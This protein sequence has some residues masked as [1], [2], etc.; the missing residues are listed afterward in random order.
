MRV[1]SFFLTTISAFLFISCDVTNSGDTTSIPTPSVYEFSRNGSST[2]SFTGQTTRI[3]MGEEL[4]A[5][6]KDFDNTTTELLFQ[7]YRNESSGGDDVNP[8]SSTKLN[9]SAKNIKGKVAASVDL[10]SG[11]SVASAEIKNDFEEWME[12]QVNEVFPNENTLAEPG[13]AG[14]IAEGTVT[15]YINAQGLEYDQMVNKGLIGALMTDQILNNY[16]SPAKLDEGTN[17]QENDQKVLVEGQN[18]TLM[19]HYWDE[20][21]GYVYGT[22]QDPSN[23]NAT[24]GSDD[25]FLNKYLGRL[26]GDEDFA[27]TSQEIFNAFALGRAAIVAGDYDLRDRQADILRQKISEVIGIRA[28]FYLLT[29]QDLLSQPSPDLGA[30]FH[31]LSEAYGFIYSL[32]FTRRPGTNSPYVSRTQVNSYLSLLTEG[33]GLWDVDPEALGNMA[34]QIADEFEFTT[35]QAAN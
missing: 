13:V 15:R 20:A 6:L 28:V 8:F 18:Y 33:N 17:V 4:I 27:G 25:S 1:K 10:F 21:Y 29:A 23:P 31:D 30:A 26:E 34:Q 2:V 24:I 35:E 11:E 7:M 9:S 14:Q 16:L 5:A 3:E 19:E 22:S 12:K 32:Q